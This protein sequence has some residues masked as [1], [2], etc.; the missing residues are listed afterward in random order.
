MQDLRKGPLV[1]MPEA[2]FPLEEEAALGIDRVNQRYKG[3]PVVDCGWQH[4]SHDQPKRQDSFYVEAPNGTR[5][6][7]PWLGSMIVWPWETAW[8]QRSEAVPPMFVPSKMKAK[9]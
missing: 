5:G 8:V 3:F 6:W 9:P 1:T 2:N 7:V 4:P